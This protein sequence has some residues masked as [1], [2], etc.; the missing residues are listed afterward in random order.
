MDLSRITIQVQRLD[1]QTSRVSID[2]RPPSGVG[3]L[4]AVY[5]L[6][7]NLHYANH[8]A[9]YLRRESQQTAAVERLSHQSDE[10]ATGGQSGGQDEQQQKF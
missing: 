3:N 6:G 4:N 9:L 10:T 5:D 2:C 7:R 8:L 1:A